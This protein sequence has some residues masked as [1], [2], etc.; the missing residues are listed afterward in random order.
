MTKYYVYS[1]QYNKDTDE[2]DNVVETTR[3]DKQAALSD[4]SILREVCGKKAYMEEVE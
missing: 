4:L 1:K 3:T 2:Y